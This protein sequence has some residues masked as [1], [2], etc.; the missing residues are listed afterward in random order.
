[1]RRC[2]GAGHLRLEGI[3]QRRPVAMGTVVSLTVPASCTPCWVRY[4]LAAS[5][6]EEL[7]RDV[8]STPQLIAGRKQ[9]YTTPQGVIL[10][11]TTRGDEEQPNRSRAARVRAF[12]LFVGVCPTKT[13]HST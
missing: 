10:I 4:V 9:L 6:R 1:M 2:D 11:S 3:R 5:I 12:F 13:Q 8:R 7:L